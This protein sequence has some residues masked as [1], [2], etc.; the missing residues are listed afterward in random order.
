MAWTVAGGVAACAAGAWSYLRA[1]TEAQQL[2]DD[3]LRQIVLL[4]DAPPSAP[5]NLSARARTTDGASTIVIQQLGRPEPGEHAA[6]FGAG[7]RDG[8]HTVTADGDQRRV[9][10]RTLPGGAR[11]AASQSVAVRNELAHDAALSA[12]LPLALL[13]PVLVLVVIVVT[14]WLLRPVRRLAAELAGRADGELVPVDVSAAPRELVGF[15]TALNQLLGRASV[16]L[17]GQR[18]FAA[19]A[20][21]ELRTPLAAVA[22]QAEHLALARTPDQTRQRVGALRQGLAQVRRLCD[23]LLDLAAVQEA[24]TTGTATVREVAEQVASDLAV[25]VGETVDLDFALGTA[26]PAPVNRLAATTALRNLLENALR[27]AGSDA[28]IRVLARLEPGRVRVE[29]EDDGPG[30]RDPDAVLAP[31]HREAEQEVPGSGL[32]L[33][34]TRRALEQAGGTLRLSPATTSG[35][36]PLAEFTL[37]TSP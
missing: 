20:A 36:G 13:V 26:G 22:L 32:G 4:V 24:S 3:V 30:I 35:T 29:V 27:Y 34:I 14:G 23:Q 6:E 19:E 31:F 2:Q 37:P 15:L 18:R 28:T 33:T 8:L 7:L 21:H 9:M 16:V 25:R 17:D 1:F 11:I 5:R 10:V 12:V